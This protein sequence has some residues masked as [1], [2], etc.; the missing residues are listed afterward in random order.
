M[1]LFEASVASWFKQAGNGFQKKKYWSIAKAC[2]RNVPWSRCGGPILL[3]GVPSA[4]E[5]G[6]VY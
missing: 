1:Q 4:N 5:M 2:M 6:L 3:P